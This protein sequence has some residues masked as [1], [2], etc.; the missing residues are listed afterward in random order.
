M[1]TRREFL[2]TTTAALL[3][4]IALPSALAAREVVHIVRRGDTLTSIAAHYG[5]TVSALKLHNRLRGDIIR[6]GQRLA[7]PAAGPRAAPGHA[8]TAVA[9]VA[10][11]TGKLH[12]PRGRWTH[13]VV[14]HSGI[15]DGNAKAYDGAHRRRGMEHGLA[16]H[17]VIGN[18]RD[19]GDGEIEIGPRW[20]KQLHGGHV[21]SEYHNEHGIGICLVGNFQRRRPGSR[22]LASLHALIDWL[23]DDAPLG[24][25]PKV[26]VH[27]WVD[28]N[29][30]VCPGRLFPYD[31]LKK[32]Y[33]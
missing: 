29:H 13:I 5:V 32:R 31:A 15:E 12:I 27:R 11:V 1:P 2:F 24:A 30:T 7:V 10:A 28:R 20:L 33:A 6:V 16:Y 19:S 23:R 21:R 4:W 9:R 22:Q 8:G 25:R 17:F 26:T 3:G 14:H 18:G